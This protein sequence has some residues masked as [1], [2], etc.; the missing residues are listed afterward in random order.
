MDKIKLTAQGEWPDVC[1]HEAVFL[2][3]LWA[4]LGW[5][6]PKK[7]VFFSMA[8]KRWLNSSFKGVKCFLQHTADENLLIAGGHLGVFRIVII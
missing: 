6:A 1:W 5:P 7:T 2:H 4:I 3:K 8:F